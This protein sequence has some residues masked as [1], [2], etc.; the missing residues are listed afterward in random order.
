MRLQKETIQ[1]QSFL[2]SPCGKTEQKS[3]VK[4]R[5]F[6]C[7]SVRVCSFCSYWL[8]GGSIIL[9]GNQVVL[10]TW[11]FRSAAS[12]NVDFSLDDSRGRRPHVIVTIL[13]ILHLVGRRV[14]RVR[15]KSRTLKRGRNWPGKSLKADP[16]FPEE[17]PGLRCSGGS[18]A[19]PSV[20][21]SVA[22]CDAKGLDSS[23]SSYGKEEV[24]WASPSSLDSTSDM[25]PAAA[26]AAAQ[27]TQRMLISSTSWL[28]VT[29]T[30]TRR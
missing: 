28:P 13:R 1:R 17:A 18:E 24:L 22:P 4:G 15:E 10:S 26:A 6:F 21:S 29:L 2:F 7:P 25:N 5:F 19:A 12:C 9:S 20:A 27:K 14:C 11:L 8:T 3:N 23:M 30:N 16:N